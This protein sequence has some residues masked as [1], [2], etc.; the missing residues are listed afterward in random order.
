M[1]DYLGKEHAE[2]SKA[3]PASSPSDQGV[4][5][6]TVSAGAAFKF[7]FVAAIGAVAAWGVI[8]LVV[9]LALAII[10]VSAMPWRGR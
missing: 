7:G 5:L 2:I 3:R 9:A 6:A 10:G 4:N 1:T 8:W